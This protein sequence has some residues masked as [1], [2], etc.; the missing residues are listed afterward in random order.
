MRIDT[1]AWHSRKVTSP[2]RLAPCA[3]QAPGADPWA[4][5][6]DRRCRASDA[7]GLARLLRAGELTAACKRGPPPGHA[8]ADRVREAAADP[9]SIV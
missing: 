8:G 9:Q 2:P 6:G 1:L 5:L 3:A 7:E 4:T